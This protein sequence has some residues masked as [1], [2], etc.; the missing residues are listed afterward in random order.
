RNL[1]YQAAAL[2]KQTYRI[3]KGVSIKIDKEIPVSA[4]L[5]GGSSDAAATLRAL[6]RMWSL[7]ITIRELASVG[8]KVGSDVAFCVYNS[9]GL[10]K[11]RGEIITELPAPPACWVVLAKPSIGV[12]TPSV[13]QK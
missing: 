11:G 5:G 7:N 4:G 12:S 3:K 2:F 8:V 9:T 1:V 6:N 10:V 13:F